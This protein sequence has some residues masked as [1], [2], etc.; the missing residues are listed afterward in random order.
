MDYRVLIIIAT[1]KKSHSVLL[2]DVP[3]LV[4][5]IDNIT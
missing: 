1:F 4:Y 3:G 5:C 2:E